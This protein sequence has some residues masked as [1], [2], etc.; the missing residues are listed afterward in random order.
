MIAVVE[1]A[2]DCFQ[3]NAFANSP[4]AKALF[5]D[6]IDWFS[7]EEDDW[8]FSFE[9]ICEA[10]DLNADNI[11]SGLAR[12]KEEELQRLQAQRIREIRQRE[13]T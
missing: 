13:Q 4:R 3:K 1:D 2:V 11:R 7:S 10:L 5:H 8:P 9:R 6:A 12:W